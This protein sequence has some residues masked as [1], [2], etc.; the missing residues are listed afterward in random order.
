MDAACHSDHRDE[1]K[2]NWEPME[3]LPQ[4]SRPFEAWKGTEKR[5]ADAAKD[6]PCVGPVL[7]RC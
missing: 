5:L 6:W 2:G 1:V 4:G 7:E 3:V